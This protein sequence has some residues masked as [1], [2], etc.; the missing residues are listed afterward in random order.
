LEDLVKIVNLDI[1]FYNNKKV[2]ITGHTG[3]KGS[4]LCLFLRKL[5]AN[6]VGYSLAPEI[7]DENLFELAKIDQDIDSHIGDIRDFQK[8]KKILKISQPDIIF[9]LAAQPLVRASYEDPVYNYETNVM[10]TVNL[11]EVSKDLESLKALV[12][13]TTDKCYEN[14]EWFWSYREDDTLGGHDPYS[15]SKACSEIVTNSYR[16]SFFVDKNI[17]LASARAGNVIG[18]GDFS[19]DRIIPDIVRSI[20]KNQ[21][22]VLRNPKAVRP[23]QHVLDVLYGY[24]LLGEKLYNN[25]M[26]YSESFNFSP[27]ENMEVNVERV[28]NK[29]ISVIGRGGYEINSDKTNLHE[30]QMLKLDSSKAF[31]KLNW[32]SKYKIEDAIH[33]TSDWY[34]DY[35]QNSNARTL[36]ENELNNFIKL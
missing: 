21:K 15:A 20:R 27:I 30:A 18:G 1:N 33:K 6:V 25:P 32:R 7:R 5:G 10:G 8:L 14:K 13:I 29:F 26:N 19:R 3:F 22:V 34:R 36:C 17:G 4:W 2:F 24:L 28:V 11:L 31:K 16:K 35:L 9:H 12:N 23:W